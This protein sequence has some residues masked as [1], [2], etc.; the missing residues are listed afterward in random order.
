MKS[1]NFNTKILPAIQK[2]WQQ[3]VTFLMRAS[4]LQVWQELDRKGQV[5]SW[6]AY[7]PITGRSACFG[8]EEEM[9]LWIEQCYYK[10]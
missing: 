10:S 2:T 1:M 5:F 4:E 9:R 3:F 7:D 8:S 6:H